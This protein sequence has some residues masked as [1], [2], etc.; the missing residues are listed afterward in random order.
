MD[1]LKFLYKTKPGRMMLKPLINRKMSDVSGK[2]LDTKASKVLIKRF[3]EKN[4]INLNDYHVDDIG[5]FND[6]FCRRIREELRPVNM[7]ENAL[8]CPCD[9]LLSVSRIEEGKVI[10]AKQSEYTI[11]S[12]L[13]D[14]V[15]ADSFDGG[16]ALVFRLCV[17]NYHRY[18]YFD[19]GVKEKDRGI[20]G[21][22]HTVRP[23]ALE[24]LSVFT[25]NQRSYS[26]MDTDSFGKCV[27]MEVGAM[28]V[29]KIVNEHPEEREVKRGEEKG[30]FEYGGSTVIVLI[31]K[32]KVILRE[33][34]IEF[35]DTT[36]EIPVK[37][38]QTIGW[39]A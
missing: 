15:L 36:L 28:L 20:E 25:E 32:D 16:Y 38:G 6:F 27:Q 17:D 22:F 34:L 12:L 18:M 3:T 2:L 10:R 11:K 7:D 8:V 24:G 9:G 31:G 23:I 35:S 1:Y 33:D 39:K 26:V 37:M 13:R 4:D 29:G 5:S 14:E 21:V 19:S 30:H